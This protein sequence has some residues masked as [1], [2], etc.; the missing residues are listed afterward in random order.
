VTT[1]STPQLAHLLRTSAAGWCATEAGAQLLC[2]HRSLLTRADFLAACV[3]Y[4][5][6]RTTAVAWVVWE[7]IPGYVDRAALSSSE[8]RILRLAAELGGTDTGVPLDELL[9]G[10][11]DSN[12]R[13]IL[14][15]IAHA[16]RLD[17]EWGRR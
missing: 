11:D 13:L 10:L 1:L 6:N 16:L 8:V 15:A 4:D 3:E 9:S 14:D 2:E 7:A 12:A 17:R 5:H